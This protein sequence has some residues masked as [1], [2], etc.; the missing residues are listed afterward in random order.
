MFISLTSPD[1]NI[2]PARYPGELVIRFRGNTDTPPY[3][4]VGQGTIPLPINSKCYWDLEWE[5]IY[6]WRESFH[7]LLHWK[8]FQLCQILMRNTWGSKVETLHMSLLDDP[9]HN[10]KVLHVRGKFA[11]G[12][13][14]FYDVQPNTS[15]TGP[16]VYDCI[17]DGV[18]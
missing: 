12:L 6:E 16:S 8:H 4:K 7:S 9:S 10:Y 3:I 11:I 1:P 15:V 13:P 5:G 17:Y 2:D 14:G 18:L